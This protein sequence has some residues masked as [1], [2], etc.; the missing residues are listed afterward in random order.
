MY[1]ANVIQ[2]RN[3]VR[4]P[5]WRAC[6]HRRRHNGFNHVSTLP[7]F[8]T[9]WPIL[10]RRRSLVDSQSRQRSFRVFVNVFR[11]AGGA[12]DGTSKLRR[13]GVPLCNCVA[14][15]PRASGRPCRLAERVLT[16]ATRQRAM[17]GWWRRRFP[18][19]LN[20]LDA[21]WRGYRDARRHRC[22]SSRVRLKS[23]STRLQ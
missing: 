18:I 3:H 10:C 9:Q 19:I 2:R 8:R 13:L 22:S 4:F 5:R 17:R 15:L 12:S 14:E 21:V 20:G 11:K 16:R 1:S 6:T 23:T 7:I